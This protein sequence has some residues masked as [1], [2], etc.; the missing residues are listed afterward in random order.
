MIAL[1]KLS[2]LVEPA[3]LWPETAAFMARTDLER[4]R[5]LGVGPANLDSITIHML[6]VLGTRPTVRHRS[7]VTD[8]I[9][10]FLQ[11]AGLMIAEDIR[12]YDS[13]ED[14]E[15]IADALVAEGRPLFW[16]YPLRRGRFHESVHL[17]RTDLWGRLNSKA[18]L[19]E[20]APARA[21]APRRIVP[22]ATLGARLDHPAVVKAGGEEATGWGG[23]VRFCDTLE[24]LLNVKAEFLSREISTCVVE[25]ELPVDRC[26]CANL[27]ISEAGVVYLG[28]AE[29]MFS[30][31]GRQSGSLVDPRNPL[32]PEG[33]D[34][35]I[36]I[37]EAARA[38]GFIGVAGLDI[39]R[40]ADGRLIV[41]DP[42][43]RF[44]AC[45]QQILLHN[46]A[47]ERAGLT[48]S[49]SVVADVSL[50]V[51]SLIKRLQ[52]AVEDGWFVPTRIVDR[53]ILSNEKGKS[54]LNGF[55]LGSD[56]LDADRN[57]RL[58]DQLLS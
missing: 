13:A 9:L 3:G 35:A 55:V 52:S 29:Q 48:V 11:D 50:S 40:I 24:S 49:R 33:V 28:A 43:F 2:P 30:A 20:I 15:A 19:A 7:G 6:G 21:L 8:E 1:P 37:G 25:Q 36:E 32:P 23:T 27:A 34:L 38:M 47:T 42:N 51:R 10:T 26:W 4:L 16:P 53:S 54:I 44:N 22:T 31:P 58:L 56:R 45:T 5:L 57:A 14:A 17:V 12:I 39:G 46:A 41:F 18:F